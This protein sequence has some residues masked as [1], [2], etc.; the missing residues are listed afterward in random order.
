MLSPSAN[1]G[2]RRQRLA[3]LLRAIDAFASREWHWI[4][5]IAWLLVCA[6][7][8][9]LYAASIHWFSLGDTDDNMR[10]LQVHDWL[11]NGQ[12]WWD[13]T[14]HRMNPPQGANIHWSR[15]VDL[16]IAAL[17]L[18]FRLFM[19]PGGADRL[20]CGIAPLLPLLPLM[21]ALAFLTRRLSTGGHGWFAAMLLPLG[22]NMGLSMF[23]PLRID[24]HGWQLALASM[25][26][27]GLV[28]RKWLRGG[29]IAGITSAASIAIGMEMIVYLAGA[30]AVVALR[31]IFKEGAARRLQPY[32]VSLAGATAIGYAGFASNAN[33]LPVCDALSPVWTSILILAAGILLTISMLPLRGWPQRLT[34]A[35]VGGAIIL[36]FGYA[37]WPQCLTNVYQISPELQRSWLAYIR[38][39]KPLYVE[40]R[41]AWV[42]MI[43]M[44]ATGMI[45]ALAGCWT[46]RWDRERLWAWG[47]VTLMIALAIGLMFW[48]IRAGPAAQ[49][50]SI[51]PIGWAIWQLLATLVRG[52]WLTRSAALLG[53]AGLGSAVWAYPLYP[54]ANQAIADMNRPETSKEAAPTKTKGTTANMVGT[55]NAKIASAAKPRPASANARCRTLPALQPL[56]QL[57]PAILFTMVDL[58]P[59]IIAV[60]HHSVI[61]GPYHRNGTAILDIHHAFDGSP[62]RFR[63][64]AAAHHARYL[65]ICPGFPEGTIYQ[66]RSPKG[67]Y[68]RLMRGE[69]FDFLKPVTLNST[70]ALPYT[71]YRILPVAPSAA[72]I[73]KE[74]PQKP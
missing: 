53:L 54:V 60:T 35:A 8:L 42:P 43:A 3:A 28:D 10:Y 31:W 25:T 50:L 51:P 33:R 69:T 4:V 20:A 48:Q 73:G 36:G 68:A 24:H 7:Y 63:A 71:L 64:I 9:N 13:L 52:R 5:V 61:A 30:G 32:A 21:M 41:S 55:G 47:T 65:L 29:I 44:P 26:L 67:F 38:E 70:A 72:P 39:A 14:Q 23:M 56:D 45:C 18:F 49:L 74:R 17:M 40:A 62:E 19:S 11:F 16:P 34:A 2:L 15:L 37:N 12:S 6:A 1:A 59:R 57:P 66:R 22:A 46:V 58:G 27:A